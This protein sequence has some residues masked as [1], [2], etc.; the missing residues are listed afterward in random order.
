MLDRLREWAVRHHRLP[1]AASGLA[2]RARLD[3]IAG[4]LDSA[5]ME[6]ADRK[7]PSIITLPRRLPSV[8]RSFKMFPAGGAD[9]IVRQLTDLGWHGFE[10]P[11]PDVFVALMNRL[12]GTVIDIGANTGF[13]SILA[14][15]ASSHSSVVAFE[16]FPPV[17]PLLEA[18]LRLNHLE[19]RVMVSTMAISDTQG[20]STLYIPLQ[21][22]GLVE[23]SCY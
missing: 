23:S 2:R 20:V 18:N 13:Y 14:C 16:P 7:R 1:A 8:G 11:M 17:V 15:V 19:R 5:A 12:G 10:R 3:A 4:K 9:L 21:D 6:G 22:H